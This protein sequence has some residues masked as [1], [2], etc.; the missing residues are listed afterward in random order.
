MIFVDIMGGL[1]NQLFQYAAAKSLAIDKNT[2][3]LINLEDYEKED[4]KKVDHV[5]FKLNHFNIDLD[6]M[7][8]TPDEIKNYGNVNEIIEPL[9]SHNFVNYINLNKYESNIHLKGYWQDE[10]YFKHNSNAIKHDLT[11]TTPPNKRNKS[12]LDEINNSESICLSFRRGEYLDSYFIGQYGIC[13]KD[14]Y[15]N[16]IKFISKI[17]EKP[18]FF[19]FSDDT[20]WI[21]DNVK[22]DYPTIPV[23]I[24]GVGYEYEELRLMANCNHFIL[25]NSSFSWWG[26]WL[27]NNI[28][29][30][31]FAPTP[32]FNSFTKQHILC[33]DWIHLKCDRSDIFNQ[34]EKKS[35]ELITEKDLDYLQYKKIDKTI[36]KY[37][38][39]LLINKESQIKFNLDQQNISNNKEHIIEFKIYSENNGIIKVDYGERI[40]TLGYE[41]GFSNKYLHLSEIDLNS[42]KLTF[43][44]EKLSIDNITIKPVD[45]KFDLK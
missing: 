31:V 34:A 7:I 30:K 14:Y 11:I 5:E 27:S 45:S 8:T 9:S 22:L 23:N 10:R 36:G 20:D 18:V 15:K 41:K 33:P 40:I 4:A 24:N 38:I 2:E 37:G 6:N 12:L 3:L 39:K 35:F 19:I 26:A 29:K 42:I 43:N 32:W 28:N 13:T 44:D 16:A 21:T 1:G 25:A 17:V